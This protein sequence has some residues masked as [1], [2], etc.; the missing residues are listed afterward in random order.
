M[1]SCEVPGYAPGEALEKQLSSQNVV[2]KN[3]AVF[4]LKLIAI[5]FKN[6]F[7]GSQEPF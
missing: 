4:N 6:F 7:V 1:A 5:C 3:L 2:F